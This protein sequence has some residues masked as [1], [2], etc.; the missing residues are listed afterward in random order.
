MTFADRSERFFAQVGKSDRADSRK[1]ISDKG[2]PCFD[3]NSKSINRQSV[4]LGRT[5]SEKHSAQHRE[6]LREKSLSN[7]FGLIQ[8]L[9][10]SGCEGH[11]IRQRRRGPF[12][13][14]DCVC[15]T[16]FL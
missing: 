14:I 5:G 1:L 11:T 2:E 16:D 15:E 6:N 8:Q 13:P 3:K 10:P 9:I 4:C 12:V 7:D